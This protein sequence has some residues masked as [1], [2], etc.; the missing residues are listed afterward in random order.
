M[1]EFQRYEF[2]SRFLFTST[3]LSGIAF[4]DVTICP[5]LAWLGR[6]ADASHEVRSD[7]LCQKTTID[8]SCSMTTITAVVIAIDAIFATDVA[9]PAAI[10]ISV[11]C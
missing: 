6:N 4:W 1:A 3:V 9:D 8:A 11:D 5:V 2:F 7:E 10:R